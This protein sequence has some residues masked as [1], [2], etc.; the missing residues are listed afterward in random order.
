MAGIAIVY[1]DL[2]TKIKNDVGL[3]F[4]HIWNNQLQQVADGETYVFPFPNAFVEISA[5][6]QYDQL[7]SGYTQGN[8]IIRIH[9]G[10]EEYDAGNGNF[11][12]N[13]N[14]FTYRDAV[15]KSLNNFQ[16]TSC[17]SMMKVSES[18]DYVHT[19][20]YHYI[21]EFICSF[22]DSKGSKDEQIPTVTIEPPIGIEIDI[23]RVDFVDGITNEDY[24]KIIIT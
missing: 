3:N 7:S 12:E 18:Q 4:V 23:D 17:S 8:L 21:I 22:V 11:E 2:I 1:S 24:R 20:I 19:N 16:P 6:T 13:V 10:H 14:V 9:V 5:P 15:I